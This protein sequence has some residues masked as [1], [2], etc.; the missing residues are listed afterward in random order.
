MFSLALSVQ[1]LCN[2][3]AV[4]DPP[5]RFLHDASC[6]V[7][8]SK[9]ALVAF[10]EDAILLLDD[11]LQCS[12]HPCSRGHWLLEEI[13]ATIVLDDFYDLACEMQEH[14]SFSKSLLEVLLV[15][16]HVLHD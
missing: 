12:L 6:S 14:S 1:L 13:D 5:G 10:R 3:R 11:L 16:I 9:L 2:P 15:H 8:Q 7:V 4:C